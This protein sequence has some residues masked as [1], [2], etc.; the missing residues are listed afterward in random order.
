MWEG[1]Y[2]DGKVDGLWTHWHESGQSGSKKRFKDGKQDGLWT[3][4]YENGQ[5]RWEENY[6]DGKLMSAVHW[7]QNGEK[8]PVTNVKE[9]NGVV[10]WYKDD[11]TEA[12]RLTYKD[13]ELVDD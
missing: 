11:G 6:R 12:L 8:C 5:K 4:W 13:G 7:K 2:K 10:V 1:T 9:G 3:E